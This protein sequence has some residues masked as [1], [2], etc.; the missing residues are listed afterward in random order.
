MD[1]IE[2]IQ[3]GGQGWL[4]VWKV[5]GESPSWMWWRKRSERKPSTTVHRKARSVYEVPCQDCAQV[6][7]GETSWTLR[8]SVFQNTNR[9]WRG[10]MTIMGLLSTFLNTTT[11]L[12]GM[13]PLSQPRIPPIGDRES[14]KATKHY[15]IFPFHNDIMYFSSLSN[16]YIA[17]SVL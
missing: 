10:L 9:Q 2:V 5:R 12:P 13:K 3:E 16:T 8:R 6:N 4:R 15:I 17:S 7:A 14:K 11:A 1:T